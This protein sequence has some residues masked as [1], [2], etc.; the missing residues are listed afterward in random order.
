MPIKSLSGLLNDVISQPE[1]L[2]NTLENHIFSWQ[3]EVLISKIK[4][5]RNGWGF[6]IF[7]VFIRIICFRYIFVR[8]VQ[9]TNGWF[10][11]IR[12]RI[13]RLLN[14]SYLPSKTQFYMSHVTCEKSQL[15][16]RF[17]SFDNTVW[18]WFRTG[19]Q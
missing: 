4:G 10:W 13:N 9:R 3:S 11:R 7:L 18:F 1:N 14:Y 2:K 12:C 5:N 8:W 6:N 19:T 17:G 16:R 15:R